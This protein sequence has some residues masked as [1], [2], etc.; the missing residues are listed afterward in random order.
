MIVAI[1]IRR[2]EDEVGCETQ[3]WHRYKE[4][5]PQ[6]L[7]WLN[8]VG[9]FD[10]LGKSGHLGRLPWLRLAFLVDDIT[11]GGRGKQNVDNFRPTPL[12]GVDKD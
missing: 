9:D 10:P 7:L 1:Y 12:E 11:K 2:R 5:H 4:G 6:K 8:S 3:R